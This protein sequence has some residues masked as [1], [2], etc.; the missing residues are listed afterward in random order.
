MFS[1]TQKRNKAAILLLSNLLLRNDDIQ[2]KKK[3]PNHTYKIIKIEIK[4]PTVFIGNSI[5]SLADFLGDYRVLQ[6]NRYIYKNI[7]SNF[8]PSC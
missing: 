7:Q 1:D 6:M 8:P 2:G 3:A 5:P 4:T